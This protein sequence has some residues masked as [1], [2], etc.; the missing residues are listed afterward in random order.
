M[1]KSEVFHFGAFKAGEDGVG[2]GAGADA[3]EIVGEPFVAEHFLHYGIVLKGFL[4]GADAA[5]ALE[6][7]LAARGLIVFL[8]ALTH[9]P[10]C[11]E[12]R[13][14]ITLACGCL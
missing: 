9:H 5:G 14:G 13:T 11:L 6:A 4:R 2:K 8:D 3:E 1:K 10:C 7:Y 12:A